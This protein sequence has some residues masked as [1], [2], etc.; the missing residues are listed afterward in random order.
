[1][2]LAPADPPA[3]GKRLLRLFWG[4]YGNHSARAKERPRQLVLWTACFRSGVARRRDLNAARGDDAPDPFPYP[5]LLPPLRPTGAPPSK[6]YSGYL[7]SSPGIHLHYIFI[8][9]TGAPATDPVVAW[10]NGGPGCSS[11]EGA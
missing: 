9:S 11:L 7:Q 2:E 3:K 4:R 8:E 5:L 10:F 6:W 1:M